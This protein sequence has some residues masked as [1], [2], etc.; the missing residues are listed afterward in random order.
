MQFKAVLFDMDGVLVLS[1]PLH[2]SAWQKTIQNLP[3]NKDI[4]KETD[5]IGHT[6]HQIA[7]TLTQRG[8]IQLNEE[9]LIETKQEHFLHIVN[10]QDLE[11]VPGR[12]ELLQYLSNNTLMA[13][14][15]SSGNIEIAAVLGKENLTEEF[16]FY[17]GF[18]DTQLHKPDPSPYLLALKRLN[19][20]PSDCLII[21]D[22]PS[23]VKAAKATGCQV[24]GVD[25]SGLLK[26]EKDIFLFENHHEI[27][28]WLKQA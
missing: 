2:F 12:N 11:P 9:Q 1:E 28:N 15:S 18:E 23:G 8:N 13:V 24:A 25:T 10:N 21:E 5:I 3:V 26:K 6:D 14:I 17:V 27:L 20:Q 22:S 4:L 16:Q 19:L 7:E